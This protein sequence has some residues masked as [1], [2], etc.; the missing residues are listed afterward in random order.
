VAGSGCTEPS[1]DWL[2]ATNGSGVPAVDPERSATTSIPHAQSGLSADATMQ[3]ADPGREV[4][5]RFASPGV[6]LGAGR[7]DRVTNP[8]DPESQAIRRRQSVKS[9]TGAWQI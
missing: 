7:D 8:S 3:L 5:F 6:P 2:A 4:S 9:R 1:A